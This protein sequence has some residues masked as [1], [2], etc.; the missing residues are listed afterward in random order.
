MHACVWTCVPHAKYFVIFK[1]HYML[2]EVESS[3]KNCVEL[4]NLST[5]LMLPARTPLHGIKLHHHQLFHYNIHTTQ[6]YPAKHFVPH[7]VR[8]YMIPVR[9]RW[10]SS[11]NT[12]AIWGFGCPLHAILALSWDS[13][14]C[15]SPFLWIRINSRSYCGAFLFRHFQIRKIASSYRLNKKK[16]II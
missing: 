12:L 4:S 16:A 7:F 13:K 8:Q 10:V 1:H 3:N 15:F 14:S 2:W 9:L 6:F 5:N 11:T